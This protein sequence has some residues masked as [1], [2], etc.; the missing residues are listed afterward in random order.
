MRYALLVEEAAE[1]EITEIGNWYQR[2]Q[3]GLGVDFLIKLGDALDLIRH[4]PFSFPE[5]EPEIRRVI[6]KKYPYVIYFAVLGKRISVLRVRHTSR[7][8]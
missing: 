2:Q 5:V 3:K 6:M 8:S 7:D 1:D 4:R